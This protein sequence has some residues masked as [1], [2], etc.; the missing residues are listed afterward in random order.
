M[1]EHNK[2]H[3]KIIKLK[4]ENEAGPGFCLAKW[5]HV[6]MYLQSGETHSCYHP[7]P[8]RI[9]L[10]E[11]QDNPSALHNTMHKKLERKEMLEGGRP[12]GCSYCWNIEDLGPDYISDRH[13]RNTGIYSEEKYNQ[14]LQG[15]WDQ[16]VDPVYLEIN[17]GNECNFK[18]GYCHPKFSSSYYNEAK[19]FGPIANVREHNLDLGHLNLYTREEE[20]P[21]VDAFWRWWPELS[22]TLGVFRI[23]GGE[24][25]MHKS[26]WQVFDMLAKDPKPHMELSINSNLGVKAELVD[27]AAHKLVNLQ[28]NKQIRNFRLYTSIDTWGPRAQ[29]IRSGL[30][31]KLWES[32]FHNF[33]RTTGAPINLMITFNLLC[34][35][36]FRS[37]LEKIVE[38]REEYGDNIRFDTPYL[39]RPIQYDINLLPKEKYLDLM[40]NHLDFIAQNVAHKKFTQVEYDKFKRVVDY[41]KTTTYSQE[42]LSKGRKDFVNFFTALDHRRGTNFAETFPELSGLFNEWRNA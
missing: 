18:C 31:L 22:K 36:T 13:L 30:D 8:H 4:V 32:N 34:V 28:K 9:P 21:Y 41:M 3:V 23:T 19:K 20:N 37:L 5:H 16:N 10:E 12:K 40:N 33:L 27:K 7:M 25:L 38:W 11:L 17:F 24:P 14:A 39:S 35:T 2:E 1:N 26:T 42:R 29:Y 15:P 6:T